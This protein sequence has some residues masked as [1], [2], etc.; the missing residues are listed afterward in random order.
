MNAPL[1][2]GEAPAVDRG[3]GAG[4]PSSAILMSVNVA[5]VG[6]ERWRERSRAERTS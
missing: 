4:G 2:G 1:S 5:V 6:V 3:A